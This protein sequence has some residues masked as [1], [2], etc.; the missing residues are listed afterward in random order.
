MNQF[1]NIND[2][3]ELNKKIRILLNSEKGKTYIKQNFER[4]KKLLIGKG[5]NNEDLNNFFDFIRNLKE[6]SEFESEVEDYGFWADLYNQIKIP[7]Y[8][9]SLDI[10]RIEDRNERDRIARKALAASDGKVMKN[11]VFSRILL[12]EDKEA[13]QEKATVMQYV[14]QSGEY[15]FRS[16]GTSGLILQT[17]NQIVKLTLGK[18]KF[19]I[20]YHPRIMMP[21]FRK[22][23]NDESCLEVFNYGNAESADITDEKL[24]EIYKE[25]EAD[26]ILWGDASKRN[27][28]VLTQ[29]NELPDFIE[30]KEFNVFGFLEDPRFP[31]DNHK[32][33]K[34]GDIVVCDLDMLYAKDD[35]S[36][37][38]G[39]VDDI[40]DSYLMMK[41]IFGS[42]EEY[43][44]DEW[45]F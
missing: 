34:A 38:L 24:L 16:S 31:T 36:Y 4:I 39:D 5:N 37:K 1:D 11:I 22:K 21:Y 20:P 15:E 28:L 8:K 44:N 27:L 13:R 6:I 23:Y 40:I 25:L 9:I 2:M 43:T 41:R 45:D 14:A 17:G 29:D 33:L 42:N 12:S 19:E 3:K 26:G 35:P 7:E 18:R 10:L 30:S 32:A